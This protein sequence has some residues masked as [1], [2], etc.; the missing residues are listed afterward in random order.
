MAT[1]Y[2]TVNWPKGPSPR[3]GSVR[4]WMKSVAAAWASALELARA[5]LVSALVILLMLSL[6]LLRPESLLTPMPLRLGRIC[7]RTRTDARTLRLLL[8]KVAHVW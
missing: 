2:A 4:R 3:S 1:M 6:L 7:T 8:L 5:L